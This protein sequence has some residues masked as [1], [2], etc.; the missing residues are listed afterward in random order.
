MKFLYPALLIL[1]L[2][3]VLNG[4]SKSA[5]DNTQPAKTD[6]VVV[7]KPPDT[8]PTAIYDLS[9]LSACNLFNPAPNTATM[10]RQDYNELS[11]IAES[12]LTPGVL[13]VFEDG[14]KSNYIY[15]T[16]K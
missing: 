8:V 11:G 10:V 3:I 14:S 1:T 5:S 16:N 4:C 7:V 12:H 2:V 9:Q 13:Y 15:L 6:T